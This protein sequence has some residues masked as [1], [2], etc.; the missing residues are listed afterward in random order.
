MN[1]SMTRAA[2]RPES[3]VDDWLPSHE[4]PSLFFFAEQEERTERLAREELSDLLTRK[5]R[6][7]FP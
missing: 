2:A 6:E 1:D 4:T 3:P 5:F 7:F